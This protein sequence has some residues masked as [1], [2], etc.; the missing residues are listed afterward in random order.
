MSDTAPP[1]AGL[2]GGVATPAAAPSRAERLESALKEKFGGRL[3]AAHSLPDELTC[4]LAAADLLDVARTL[5]D[6]EPFKFEICVDVCGVDYLQYGETEWKTQSATS[7]GFSRGVTRLPVTERE[8]F[9][10]SRRFAVVYHLLSVTHNQRLRLR[11]FCPDEKQPIVDSV[12]PVW[13]SADWFERE[14]F[15]LFGILFRSHPDLRR[16]LTGLWVHRPSVP[17]GFSSVRQCRGPLRPGKGPRR[18]S[19][20]EHRTENP[21]AEGHP[22]RQSIRCG[23]EGFET[24]WLKSAI[25]R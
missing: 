7:S 18:L 16:L 22:A 24:Q 5:R 23:V 4:E 1:D 2:S 8:G 3:V 11:V 19:A 25:S 6:E 12:T 15:D 21:R 17:Q 10:R 9:D 14:A 13:A 20:G